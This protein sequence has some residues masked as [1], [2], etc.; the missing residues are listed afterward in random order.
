MDGERDGVQVCVTLQV[1]D[2]D[3]NSRHIHALMD[4]VGVMVHPAG[5][6]TETP[7][8]LHESSTTT[9]DLPLDDAKLAELMALVE[10]QV[11]VAG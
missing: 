9:L 8:S 10:R 1:L 7:D 2:Q 6:P 5:K 4:R 3:P 11:Q